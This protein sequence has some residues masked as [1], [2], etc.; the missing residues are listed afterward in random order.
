[1]RF[2]APLE[3]R[4]FHMFD[5]FFCALQ[6]ETILHTPTSKDLEAKND[7]KKVTLV[8]EVLCAKKELCNI[9]Y[10]NCTRIFSTTG[11]AL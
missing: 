4:L 8:N 1:M 10:R 11:L 9:V 5:G 6:V 7:F 3:R 2:L